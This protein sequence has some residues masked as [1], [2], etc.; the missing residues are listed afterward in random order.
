MIDTC[1]YSMQDLAVKDLVREAH[2]KGEKV[3]LCLMQ[4]YFFYNPY[5]YK[6]C[7]RVVVR[8]HIY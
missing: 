8:I 7:M 5:D 1:I 6:L 3:R 2:Y 4:A